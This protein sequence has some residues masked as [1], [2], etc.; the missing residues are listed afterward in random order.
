MA[1]LRAG[2]CVWV[3][4]CVF[5]CVCV[6][7]A[8]VRSHVFWLSA[9]EACVGEPLLTSLPASSMSVTECSARCLA[10]AACGGFTVTA[11]AAAAT[12]EFVTC[13]SVTVTPQAAATCFSKGG[14]PS[15]VH[16]P[17][18]SANSADAHLLLMRCSCV[19]DVMLMCY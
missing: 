15:R 14:E 9:G 18:N 4:M 1:G 11:A 5:A 17:G 19:T 3:C 13:G 16:C 10:D 6:C 12:C 7:V 8:E 2:V